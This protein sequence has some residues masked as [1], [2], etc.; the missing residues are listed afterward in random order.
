MIWLIGSSGLLGRTIAELLEKK[1]IPYIGGDK[2]VDISVSK[3]VSDFCVQNDSIK[4]IIN[5]AAYTAV[6]LAEN[7]QELAYK[8]NVVGI[9]NLII[10][11]KQMNAVLINISTDYVYDGRQ[12]T[13]YKEIDI[14]FPCG[15]YGKTKYEGDKLIQNTLI[16]YYIFR[17]AWLYGLFGNNFVFK[18]LKLMNTKDKIQVVNDQFGSP[19]NAE[20][21]AKIIFKFYE[22]YTMGS[23]P[24]YGLY[25]ITDTGYTTWFG[26]AK[27]IYRQGKAFG[28][29]TKDCQIEA[30]TTSEYITKAKRPAYSVLDKNKIKNI[31]GIV[32]PEWKVSLNN[33]FRNF[34]NDEIRKLHE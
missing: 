24:N 12:S 31:A 27:E 9:Q 30:C 19:T 25:N 11:A 8:T 14:P 29:I 16:R 21:L 3:E 22:L 6:D 13:P 15:V 7:E 10:A 33:F 2:K 28:I 17:T 5:C 34:T 26:F 18:M 4:W 23:P 1:Y 32:L 20:T